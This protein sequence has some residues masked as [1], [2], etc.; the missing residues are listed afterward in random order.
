V[1]LGAHRRT[2]AYGKVSLPG[3]ALVHFEIFAD[4]VLGAAFTET[5]SGS[6]IRPLVGAGIGERLLVTSS[7]A[8]TARVGGELYAEKVFVNGVYGTHATG[9]FTIQLGLSFYLPGGGDK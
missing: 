9:F 3:D 4:A 2:L 8:I 7:M 5:D 6:G 1:A